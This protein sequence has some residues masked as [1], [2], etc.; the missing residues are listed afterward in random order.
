MSTT[1]SKSKEAL[2]Q[3][4]FVMSK[5]D[6]VLHPEYI[7]RA[8]EPYHD[9]CITENPCLTTPSSAPPPSAIACSI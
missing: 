3:I 4:Q 1:E 5:L 8:F 2:R 7:D 9:A 6:L